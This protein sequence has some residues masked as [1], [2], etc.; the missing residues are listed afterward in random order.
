MSKRIGEL[1]DPRTAPSPTLTLSAMPPGLTAETIELHGETLVLFSFPEPPAA[2]DMLTDAERGI[3]HL[4][5]QGL[6]T[7]QIASARGVANA[8][9][10]S[11]LQSIYR[12]LGVT[13]RAELAGKLG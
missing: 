7:A 1:G 13:S 12:K 3:V 5:L 2:T 11:Q 9:V 8:T 4:L 6:T 10:S